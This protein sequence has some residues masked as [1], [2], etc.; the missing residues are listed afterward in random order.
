MKLLIIFFVLLQIFV[1][2]K[3]SS[4]EGGSGSRESGKR[5]NYCSP[6][7]CNAEVCSNAPSAS[8]K[9]YKCYCGNGKSGDKCQYG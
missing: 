2:A 5:K 1:L 6:N 8:G 7:P 3:S 9:K 4:R